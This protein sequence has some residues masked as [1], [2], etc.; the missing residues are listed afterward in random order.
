MNYQKKDW[1]DSL[2]ITFYHSVNYFI[3]LY[4]KDGN[5]KN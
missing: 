1:L 5:T 3:D 2:F 4:Y